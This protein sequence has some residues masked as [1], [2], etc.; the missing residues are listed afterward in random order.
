MKK[1]KFNFNEAY[2]QL[3]EISQWFQQDDVDLDEA[4]EKFQLGI[5][6]ID[7]CK[8][9]LTKVENKFK[10]VRDKYLND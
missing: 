1:K 10:Q 5:Q 7:K 8:K 2:K 3:E 4:L 6:L 9:E